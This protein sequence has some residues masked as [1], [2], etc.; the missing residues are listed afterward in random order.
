MR[1]TECY[2]AKYL[3]DF[4]CVCIEFFGHFLKYHRKKKPEF[5]KTGHRKKWIYMFYIQVFIRT[6]KWTYQIFFRCGKEILFMHVKQ[7]IL[8][9]NRKVRKTSVCR[10][11]NSKAEKEKRIKDT[12]NVNVRVRKNTSFVLERKSMETLDQRSA[13]VMNRDTIYSSTDIIITTTTN[14]KSWLKDSHHWGKSTI[15]VS[16]WW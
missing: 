13:L 11:P 4:F 1:L 5:F 10:F 7:T 2:Y 16:R 12:P 14:N 6:I 3:S 15:G 9:R 8:L